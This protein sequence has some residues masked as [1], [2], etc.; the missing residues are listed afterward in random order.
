[1]GGKINYKV[2]LSIEQNKHVGRV[3]YIGI[4]KIPFVICSRYTVFKRKEIIE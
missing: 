4:F 1:M 2:T 3:I